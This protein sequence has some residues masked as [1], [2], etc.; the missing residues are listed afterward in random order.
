MKA[1]ILRME[2]DEAAIGGDAGYA[3]RDDSWLMSRISGADADAYVTLVDRHIDRFLAV[4]TRTL[5]NSAEAEDIVQE[6]FLRV[7]TKAGE[8][9]PQGA[10]FTTWFYRV[11]LNLCIDH[12]RRKRP[13]PLPDGF[14]VADGAVGAERQMIAAQKSAQVARALDTLPDR[15][16]AA[17][18]LCYYE[19]L[20]N[21]EAAEILSV[22]VKALESL[23]VRG[24][25]QLAESLRADKAHLLKDDVR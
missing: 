12:K 3:L 19:G 23:L 17:L 21:A 14:D 16:K 13:D 18:I 1:A 24:R 7:W 8:W 22:G 10:K 5:G 9:A 6:A 4:A 25:R 15:Q 20:S 11:V 2:M